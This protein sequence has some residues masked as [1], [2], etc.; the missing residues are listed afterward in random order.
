MTCVAASASTKSLI[1]SELLGQLNELAKLKVGD[2]LAFVNHE[3]SID[4]LS[5]A[6]SDTKGKR[7]K[8]TPKSAGVSSSSAGSSATVPSPL[9][10]P[11]SA[12]AAT[13]PPDA[14]ADQGSQAVEDAKDNSDEERQAAEQPTSFSTWF[15]SSISSA[16]SSIG[17]AVWHSRVAWKRRINGDSVQT[18]MLC[19]SAL[20]E[21]SCEMSMLLL[22]PLELAQRLRQRQQQQH[23]QYQQQTQFKSKAADSK[24]VVAPSESTVAGA[25]VAVD[26][27]ASDALSNEQDR[28]ADL[29]QL[30]DAMAAATDGINNF[31]ATYKDR[32][33][34]RHNFEAVSALNS[35]M[36]SQAR[37]N[38]E[39]IKSSYLAAEST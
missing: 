3:L 12:S 10:P 35:R 16:A 27:F 1:L 20:I 7:Q 28:K 33:G 9:L 23:Q 30:T 11:Q 14:G 38:A 24:L 21:K 5:T 26:I 4:Q 25:A 36:V 6:T 22:H 2:K 8:K 32:G 37:R 15:I 34:H 29:G 17:T 13:P 31:L 19:I 18:S 39:W